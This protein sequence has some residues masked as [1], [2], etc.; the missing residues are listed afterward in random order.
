MK[1]TDK[2]TNT[3]DTNSKI[4]YWRRDLF[5]SED[6]DRYARIW[7]RYRGSSS[8]HKPMWLCSD[9]EQAWFYYSMGF[10]Q[11]GVHESLV[12]Q[13]TSVPENSIFVNLT[14]KIGVKG[15]LGMLGKLWQKEKAAAEV[16]TMIQLFE[17]ITML[18]N[19]GVTTK[20]KL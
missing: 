19:E 8:D 7:L 17:Q 20:F 15:P 5:N 9:D 12:L 16:S 3:C 4:L 10:P 1:I 18:R 11:Y 6:S 13:W 14:W 2:S